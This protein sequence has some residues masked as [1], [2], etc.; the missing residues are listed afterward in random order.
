MVSCY[1]VS[2]IREYMVI[3]IIKYIIYIFILITA[4]FL[5]CNGRFRGGL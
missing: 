4:L 2:K 3:Y 1:G 5:M